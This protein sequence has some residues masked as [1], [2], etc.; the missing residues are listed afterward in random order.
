MSPRQP[1]PQW[2]TSSTHCGRPLREYLAARDIQ[3]LFQFLRSRGFSRSAIAAASGLTESRVRN[4]AQGRTLVTSYDVLVRIAD[5]FGIDRG[6]LGVGSTA[7]GGPHREV[8]V[9]PGAGPGFVGS[10]AALAVGPAPAELAGYLSSTRPD[11]ATAP[12]VV[13][14]A[15]VE[16]IRTI[17]DQH[18]QI[19]AAHGGGSCRSSVVSYL[20]WASGMLASRF[21]T[22]KVEADF[23]AVLSDMYQVAG[24]SSHDLGDHAAARHYLTAGLVLAREINELALIAG[25]FYRLGRVSIHQ[26]RAQEALRLWQ[27]GQIVAQDSGNLSAVA[28]LHANEAWAYAMLGSG[29]RVCDSLAR[30]KEELGRIDADTVPA[31]AR[32]FLAPADLD[33]ISGVIYGCLAAHQEHRARFAPLAI[34]H[35]ERAYAKRGPGEERSRTFDA[36]SVAT[37]YILDAQP[38]PATT[39]GHTA[40]DLVVATDS[41]R[42]TD[43]LRLMAS[44]ARG[45]RSHNGVGGVLERVGSLAAH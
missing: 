11:A 39:A 30:A 23:K 18:R 1:D 5:G 21:E 31:W 25:G 2:W 34:E 42:A 6:L 27:L 45:Y 35:A 7:S 22:E 29:D 41:A 43:R 40:V 44:L 24:W 12:S 4:I 32:F 17:R 19:D 38:E 36:I 13:S 37:G 16:L 26:G 28:V 14:A 20:T 15:T 3:A 10:L 33:G 9:D 8:A